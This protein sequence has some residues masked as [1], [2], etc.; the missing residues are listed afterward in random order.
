MYFWKCPFSE[1]K[2]EK[3]YHENDKHKFPQMWICGCALFLIDEFLS[4]L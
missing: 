1:G 4:K 3:W 2:N